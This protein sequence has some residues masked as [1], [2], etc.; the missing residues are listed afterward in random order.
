MGLSLTVLCSSHFLQSNAASALIERDEFN[1]RCTAVTTGRI[2]KA[3]RM[4]G[5]LHHLKGT[6]ACSAALTDE[7]W[8]Q[9]RATDKTLSALGASVSAAHLRSVVVDLIASSY[10]SARRPA[11]QPQVPLAS[12]P[13]N[14]RTLAHQQAS[15]PH[16]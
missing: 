6:E 14:H 5:A 13:R 8:L 10:R 7:V 16:S 2:L 4:L 3:V 12:H 9:R 11:P 1:R 15:S